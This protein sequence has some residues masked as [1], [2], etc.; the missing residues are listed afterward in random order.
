MLLSA[1]ISLHCY[2]L[3]HTLNV[4]EDKQILDVFHFKY[5]FFFPFSLTAFKKKKNYLRLGFLFFSFS[6]LFFFGRLGEVL[7][8]QY[9][10]LSKNQYNRDTQ[11]L[12]TS[13]YAI[14]MLPI[15]VFSAYNRQWMTSAE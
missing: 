10:L 3:Q 9:A 11:M 8:I 6:F 15:M 1:I 7:C 14:L 2:R 4:C 13:S 5:Y 12:I